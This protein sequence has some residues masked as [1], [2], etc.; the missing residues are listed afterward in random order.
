MSG[1]I[2]DIMED[3]AKGGFTLFIGNSAAS[4]ILA[5][6]S[7]I[8]ARLI[9]PE[10]LGLYA[11][12]LTIPSILVGL[13]DLGINPAVTYY[14]AKL[15]VEGRLELLS[16]TLKAAYINRVSVGLLVTVVFFSYSNHISSFLNRPEAS[17]LIQIS[18]LLIIAQS[19]FNLNNSA[20]LGL[21]KNGSYSKSLIVQSVG[22]LILSPLLVLVGLGV[23]GALIGHVGSFFLAS[24]IGC[25]ALYKYSLALTKPSQGNLAESLKLMVS[26]GFPLYLSSVLTIIIAQFRTL[27]LAFF[28]SDAEIGNFNVVLTLASMMNVLVFPLSALFPAFSRLKSEYDL[29]MMFRICVKY[30]TL[31]IIP[32]TIVV[33]VLSEEIVF[34]L[35]GRAFTLAPHFLTLYMIQFLYVAAGLFVLTYLFSGVGKT[36]VVFRS[37]LIDIGLF[38]PLAT[39]L[40]MYYKVE[41]MIIASLIAYLAALLYRLAVAINDLKVSIDYKA[42][43]LII[44]AALMAALPTLA[45]HTLRLG[46]LLALV[47]GALLYFTFYIT[48]LPL[49]GALDENDVENL[50]QIVSKLGLL[51]PISRPIL[52]YIR[53][54]AKFRLRNR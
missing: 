25:L 39:L 16:K 21:E 19:L 28:S 47:I 27:I 2:R 34:T 14:S 11:L 22:K 33:M 12:S 26:Y 52:N 40:T 3:F 9:G 15:R 32:A 20:F 50:E 1:S 23:G 36:G 54:L 44:L 10:G 41:G 18:S 37:E 31:F 13:I 5:V 4:I 45:I 30:A 53:K 38:L 48:L 17:T 29:K 51:W 49:L 35:Y 46:N 43:S 7:I 42:S 8:V 6:G 24:I